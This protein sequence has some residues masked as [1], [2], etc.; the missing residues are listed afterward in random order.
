MILSVRLQKYLAEA[1]VA[2]R[3]ASEEIIL[4]GR[5]KVNGREVTLLGSKVDPLHDRVTL[6]GTAVRP[7][8]KLYVAL[9]KPRRYLCSRSDDKDGRTIGELLPNKYRRGMT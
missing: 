3:R 2:S 6:D 5:V 9:H 1:G 8:K 4:A 7:K